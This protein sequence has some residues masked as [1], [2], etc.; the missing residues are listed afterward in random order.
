MKTLST[1]TQARIVLLFVFILCYAVSFAN[2]NLKRLASKMIPGQENNIYFEQSN[3]NNDFF[4]LE[5]IKGKLYIRGNNGVSM[6]RG[7]NHYLRN[8]L[9]VTTSCTGNNI[10]NVSSLPATNGKVRIEASLPLR[11]YLNYCTYSYSMAYWDWNQWEE[12]IDR[13]ALQG[14][15]MPLVAVIGQYAVWQNTLRRLGYTEKEIISFLPGPGYEAWWLMGN[16]EEAGGPVSQQFIDR[17]ADLQKKMLNRMREYGME[18]VLQG[19]Y[20][21]V[22]NSLIAKHPE[23][24]IR[25]AGKWITYQ[26]P[27]FLSPSDPL[28]AK[29][30]RIFYEEQEKLFGKSRYYG[31]D[32]FHEGG[33]SKEINIT[34]AASNIYKSMKDI[35]PE[36]V[37]ILQG[38]SGNPS[39]ALL[40]GLKQGEALVLDLMACARPQWGGVPSS[41]FHREDGFLNHNWVW[42]A[43]P[44]FGGRIGMYGKLNSYASGAIKALKHPK[45]KLICGVGTAPE[46]IGTNPIDYDMVY[47]VAWQK[48]TIKVENWIANYSTYR[49]GAKNKNAK[50]CLQALST[51]IYNCPTPYDGPQESF[52]C[53]RPSLKIDYVSSWG[54][55]RLY[56]NPQDVVNAL[57]LLIKASNQLKQAN[58][59]RYDLVDLTRQVIADYGKYIH[60]QIVEAYKTKDSEKF[61]FYTEKF[62]GMIA[63]QDCLLGTRPEFLVGRWI[64]QAGTC[65]F[66]PTEKE[67]YIRNAKRQITTWTSV[68]SSL[69][70]YAHKEWNGILASLYAPRWKAYFDYLQ[71]KMNEQNPKEIDF[72]QIDTEWVNNNTSFTVLPEQDAVKTAKTLYNKYIPEISKAYTTSENN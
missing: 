47:D 30:A 11:Y 17:Q 20:G 64:Q 69:H 35:N 71:A 34:E 54:T 72:M 50:A 67:Q 26:R 12:E 8:Y 25:D 7:L 33:N 1:K 32:P 61:R 21:M 5:T 48:D 15:N 6:A 24:D 37:W 38:W 53:A 49:Y 4:E 51:S 2:N 29:V 19:F 43:L 68:P 65:G 9:H 52:F 10:R 27:A 55:A 63:D 18:P 3:N 42:C 39:I 31:G 36:A 57:S 60:A 40:K 14:I 46:G 45:G 13:M 23:A 59:Y 22:P 66:S 58:T 16:L 56:Y 44:N 28:F 62:L 70:E 41:T